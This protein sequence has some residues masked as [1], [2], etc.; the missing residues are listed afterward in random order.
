MFLSDVTRRMA[1]SFRDEAREAHTFYHV[2][3]RWSS[4]TALELIPGT[5]RTHQLRVHLKYLGHPIL[6]D[7]VYGRKGSFERLALH[8]KDLGFEH[9]TTGKRVMFTTPLPKS[10]ASVL[11]GVKV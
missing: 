3:K 8:A 10:M 1:V 5:G 11:K 7:S 2:L 6:G 9:P 4:G